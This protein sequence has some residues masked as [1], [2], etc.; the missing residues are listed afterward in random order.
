MM[1]QI[2]PKLQKNYPALFQENVKIFKLLDDSRFDESSKASQAEMANMVLSGDSLLNQKGELQGLGEREELLK[3]EMEDLDVKYFNQL[4]G[5]LK[6]F[7]DN[8]IGE[9]IAGPDDRYEGRLESCLNKFKLDYV[10][11]LQFCVEVYYRLVK[12]HPYHDGNKKIGV[13]FLLDVM[14]KLGLEIKQQELADITYYV[15]QSEANKNEEIIEKMTNY[16][17]RLK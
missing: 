10:G 12:N 6:K 16:L 2:T 7:L 14:S 3:K 4:V 13:A 5:E 15:A 1:E 17:G 11:P 9:E 8:N